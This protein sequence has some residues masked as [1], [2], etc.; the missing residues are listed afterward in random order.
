LI[1]F[2]QA[3]E[4]I[5]AFEYQEQEQALVAKYLNRNGNPIEIKKFK[6]ENTKDTIIVPFTNNANLG[7]LCTAV[8]MQRD[9]LPKSP[10]HQTIDEKIA[11]N[12]FEKNLPINVIKMIDSCQTYNMQMSSALYALIKELNISEDAPNYSYIKQFIN[13]Y[14]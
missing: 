6:C 12:E 3:K 2:F 8:I 9:I 5:R 7:M 11:Q 13:E 14:E 10:F 1:V 4:Q